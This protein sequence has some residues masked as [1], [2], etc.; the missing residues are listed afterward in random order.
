MYMLIFVDNNNNKTNNKIYLLWDV[1]VLETPIR[2]TQC[3]D[4]FFSFVS[5]S[6][7]F[8]FLWFLGVVAALSTLFF[9]DFFKTKI[10]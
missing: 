2:S 7:L 3:D 4:I 10:E 9:R 5:T 1:G 6:F 8:F